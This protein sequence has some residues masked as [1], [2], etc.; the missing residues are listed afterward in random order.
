MA[1]S[2]NDL[3]SYIS[4]FIIAYTVFVTSFYLVLFIIS[5]RK[6]KKNYPLNRNEKYEEMIDSDFS[7]PVS[8]LVPA[9]NEAA[10]IYGSV[11]SLLDLQYPAYE[12]IVI[13]DG[14]TD[15]TLALLL[16]KFAMAE[17][18]RIIRRQ[19]WT[20]EVS[21][22]YRSTYYPHLYVIDKENGGKSDALNA[23]I[24]FSRYP[25]FCSL[26]GDSILESDAFLKI[27]K[28]ILDAK[29]EIVA[30]GGNVR[31]ANG[32]TIEKGRIKQVGLSANVL[33]K[34]QVIE[35][36]RAF[37]MGRIA[38]SHYNILLIV[39][40]AF[41]VFSKEWVIRAGGYKTTTVG[42]DMELIVRLHRLIVEGRHRA[43]I[44][45]IPHPVCW[46]EAPETASVLKK[47]RTRWH[48]GL[49]ESLWAHRKMLFNRKYGKIGLISMPYF[50]FVELL[51][52]IIEFFGYFI[53]VIG[54][55]RGNLYLEYAV[56]IFLITL[57]YGSCL[58]MGAVLLEEWSQR[59]YP[60][61]SDIS[62][63]F[64]FALT[65][66]LWYRFMV[67]YWR[68]IGFFQAVF[69]KKGWGH[70]ERKGVIK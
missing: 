29:E 49:F 42:E 70:I 66:S 55:W 31:I 43:A 25:Y 14:S 17:V 33:V 8:I 59:K 7:P 64:F 32:C 46:T 39:S 6:I 56:I 16:E 20:K 24:N 26:D 61:V 12:I 4:Y 67:S 57:L 52:P 21:A 27:M 50:L 18:T 48:R 53:I 15:N 60:K 2:A 1:F 47:Q 41:G 34:M 68:F 37:L 22:V 45:F 35:Y 13:N 63:L 10:G 36:L 9:F 38:L 30:V 23:G 44:H 69:Q 58:S 5:M 3:F 62:K 11:K 28:P 19:L 65:E 54:L 51:G 40:G